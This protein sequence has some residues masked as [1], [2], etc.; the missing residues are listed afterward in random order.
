M[1]FRVFKS[2]QLGT[3]KVVV[4]TNTVQDSIWVIWEPEWL[5]GHEW[6]VTGWVHELAFWAYPE[7]CVGTQMVWVA[8]ALFVDHS[9]EVP[10]GT[11]KRTIEFWVPV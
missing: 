6:T 4:F 3:M 11:W 1:T 8:G 2:E 7:P 10:A 9:H 5:Q